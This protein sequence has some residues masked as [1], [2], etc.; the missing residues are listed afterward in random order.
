MKI[1]DT[2]YCFDPNRREYNAGRIIF[3]SHFEP[4]KITG[5]TKQSWLCSKG[6]AERKVNKA[7]MRE[8]GKNGFGG[9]QWYTA[10]GKEERI[11]HQDH[12]WKIREAI[13]AATVPQLKQ[14]AEIIGYNRP[15][16]SSK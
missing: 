7:T 1:G 5:E 14:I 9:W 2:V 15:K 12:A 13:T 10:E 8:A 11:W 6:A 16:E 3:A 4:Y